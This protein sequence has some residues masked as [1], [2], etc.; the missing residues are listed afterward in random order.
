MTFQIIGAGNMAWFLTKRLLAAG[1]ECLGIFGRNLETTKELAEAVNAP[2]FYD[3]ADIKDQA[4]CCIITVSDNAIEYIAQT[5][6][7]K[8][9]VLL[10]TSGSVNSTVLASTAENYGVIWPIYSLLKTDLP[11]HRNIPAV[12]EGNTEKAREITTTVGS[13][14]T[15][16]LFPSTSEERAWL[17]L[18]AVISNNFTNHLLAICEEI[19]AEKSTPFALL[20]PIMLQTFERITAGSPLELQTGP[21][22]RGDD[23]IIQKHAAMLEAHPNW[24]IVYKALSYSIMATYKQ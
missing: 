14:F 20:F 13:S 22:K 16:M 5:L 21:A 11:E 7:L 2:Y 8:N 10:H 3:L 4:D 24:Q 6:A 12:G 9:T 19:C 18:S 17:H 23:S 1:H 15:D